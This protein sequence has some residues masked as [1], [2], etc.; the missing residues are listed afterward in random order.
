ML[1]E[2]L[3]EGPS[4]QDDDSFVRKGWQLGVFQHASGHRYAK[5]SKDILIICMWVCLHDTTSDTSEYRTESVELI[6]L[7]THCHESRFLR[8]ELFHYSNP[9]CFSLFLSRPFWKKS[10]FPHFLVRP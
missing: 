9:K 7:T 5:L 6:I 3:E 8:K 4:S 2:V 10:S 1:P